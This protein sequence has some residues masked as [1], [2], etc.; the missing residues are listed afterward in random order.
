[1]TIR[2]QYI[3]IIV[4]KKEKEDDTLLL[5]LLL[6]LV[7]ALLAPTPSAEQ[8]PQRGIRD[9]SLRPFRL[10]ARAHFHYQGPIPRHAPR[11][12]G[13]PGGTCARTQTRRLLANGR[14]LPQRPPSAPARHLMAPARKTCHRSATPSRV[15]LARPVAA[16]S[17][18][19]GVAVPMLVLARRGLKPVVQ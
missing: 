8:H 10:R 3:Q 15:H 11:S 13:M 18:R 6:T 16:G 19:A 1:M 14:Q 4:Q 7:P 2:L 17:G 5:T 12:L 9:S